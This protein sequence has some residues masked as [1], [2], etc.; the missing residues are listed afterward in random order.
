MGHFGEDLRRE[1]ES[2]GI[3]LAS[4]TEMTKISKRNLLALE[5]NRFSE[6][7]GGVF[8]RGIVRGYARAVGLDENALLLRFVNEN[9]ASPGQQDEAAWA[10]FAENVSRNRKRERQPKNGLRWAG[11]G[12]LALV[13]I[14]LGWFVWRL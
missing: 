12:M 14:C 2:R 11:V 8:N 4:I 3:P 7:P 9:D 6:L 13:L 10:G 5:E 1:R